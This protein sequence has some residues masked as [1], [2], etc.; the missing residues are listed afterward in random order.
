MFNDTVEQEINARPSTADEWL[1]APVIQ[2]DCDDEEGEEQLG[3]FVGI[4]AVERDAA[5][6]VLLIPDRLCISAVACW[7]VPSDRCSDCGS[8]QIPAHDHCSFMRHS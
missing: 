5:G 4:L 1:V 8:T 3:K 7:L 2:S 6:V